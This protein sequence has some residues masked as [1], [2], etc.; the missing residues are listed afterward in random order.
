MPPLIA[1]TTSISPGNEGRPD[2]A[3]LNGAYLRVIERAGGAPVMLAPQFDQ[4]SITAL[5]AASSGLLVTGGGDIFPGLYGQEQDPATNGVSVDRDRM[6]VEALG[7]A[8]ERGLPVL[9]ICRGM[10]LL[11]V[12]MGGSLIQDLPSQRSSHINHAQTVGGAAERN[13]VTHQVRTTQSSR[14]ARI[15]GPG[16]LQTNSMHHQAVDALGTGL[17]AVAWADDDIVEGVEMPG[18]QWVFGVQWHPEELVGIETH[19]DRLFQAFLA[20]C[21]DS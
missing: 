5:M 3:T 15:L 19:A 16:P 20:A 2:R 1:V 6:E 17:V 21:T 13:A 11:N 10:Q 7:L 14:L 18:E 12:A 8:L 4:R 9:A